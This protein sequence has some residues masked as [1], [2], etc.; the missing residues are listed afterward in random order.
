MLEFSFELKESDSFLTHRYS[1]H[2]LV[3]V[4]LNCSLLDALSD[5][6]QQYSNNNQNS[7]QIGLPCQ[8]K[9]VRVSSEGTF[10]R[11]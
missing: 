1:I 2:N 3:E 6:L 10:R 5:V 4:H 8:I 9:R 7:C 11:Q